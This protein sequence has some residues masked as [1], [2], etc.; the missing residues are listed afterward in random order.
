MV[1]V[2]KYERGFVS[3]P[4]IHTIVTMYYFRKEM[5]RQ[6]GKNG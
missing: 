4:Q 3:E 2:L 6:G 1:K 5:L